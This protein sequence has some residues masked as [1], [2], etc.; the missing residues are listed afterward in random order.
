MQF[1]KLRSKKVIEVDMLNGPIFW[2]IFAFSIPLILSS[3]LQLLFNA[4][5]I[6]VVGRFAGSEALAAV[7][8]TSAL[9][10]LLINLFMGVS[11]GA[12]V[13]MG[14]N[15]GAGRDQDASDTLHTAM[16]FS[17][18]AGIIMV[19]LGY[20]ASPPL[21]LMMGTPE[22]VLPLASLYMR[23]Y[24]IGMPAF[25]IYN[26]GAALLRAIGDTKR[27]LYFL[28]IAGIVNLCFNL[29]FVIV[30]KLSVLGVAIATVISQYVSAFLIILSLRK[31]ES[32]MRL[33]W[34][35]LRIHSSKLLEMLKIGLPA[36]LQGAI[37]SISNVLIQ[38]SVNSFGKI[39]MAGNTAASNLEGFV[40]VSMNAIYQASLS[41]TSQNFGAKQ[42]KR[43]DKILAVSLLTVSIIG[44]SLG[45]L[46]YLAGNTLL[47]IYTSD[48][49]VIKIGILRL[50]IIAI[51]YF[52]CGLMD[53]LCGSLRGL[54]YSFAPMLISLTGACILRVVWVFTIFNI[55]R[56]LPSLY[57]SYPIS[58]LLTAIM[59]MIFYIVIRQKKIKPLIKE[60]E[61]NEQ[62]IEALMSGQANE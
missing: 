3:I 9:I 1:S 30:F 29:I 6:I 11:I 61:R 21:L 27:P 39:A 49:E 44:V 50:G 17:F 48:P 15:V 36:G 43:I 20:F 38:S 31:S 33:Y 25:M 41:F 56:T 42:Y 34:D 45:V 32:Y 2:R 23:T 19:F 8:S 37:F 26:F 12:S 24:F 59:H 18:I 35:R 40:Y 46:C 60:Q 10:N 62:S 22:E 54:G 52:F 55:Y 28:T 14:R 51:P 4:A 53:V 58:W 7:G 13:V 47:S 16:T 5:D 57:I